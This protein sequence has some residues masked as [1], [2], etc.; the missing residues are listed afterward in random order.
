MFRAHKGWAPWESFMRGIVRALSSLLVFFSLLL[1]PQA[2]L[3]EERSVVVTEGADYFGSDY[4]VRK[5]VSLDQCKAACTGDNKCQA[6][7]YNSAAKWCFLKSAV[8]ELR[9]VE[10]AVSGKIVAA[11]AAAAKKRPDVEAE[12][13]AELKFLGQSY[14]DTARKFVGDIKDEE[15]P[16]GG[17]EAAIAAATA[18][19]DGSDFLTAIDNY[20]AALS[21]DPGRYDLW[22]DFTDAAIRASSDDYEVQD[23]LHQDRIAGSIN[24]YLHAVTADE[25]AHSMEQIG[26]ALADQDD[27]KPALKAYRASLALVDDQGRRTIYENM[28][29]EHGFRIVDN[30]VEADAAAP[31]ICLNFSDQLSASRDYSDFITIEGG[32]NFAI[33]AA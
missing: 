2:A 31:R 10:G 33:E 18:A 14:V 21:V 4:D 11:A 5:D 12:R 20:K 30:T 24:A 32:T 25:R 19:R 1:L 9:S 6:F 26:W 17:I 22:M 27:W 13:I 3:S 15:A 16:D 28:L 23:T 8:G 7:T 29:A